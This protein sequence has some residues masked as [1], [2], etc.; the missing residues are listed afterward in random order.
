MPDPFESGMAQYLL[1][2]EYITSIDEKTRGERMA[3]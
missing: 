2:G 3:T 1:Q